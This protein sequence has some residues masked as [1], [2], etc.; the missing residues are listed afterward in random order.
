MKIQTGKGCP[1][2]GGEVAIALVREGWTLRVGNTEEADKD[3]LQ[4]ARHMD[5]EIE[6][7]L[8]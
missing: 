8:F 3:P 1:G 4:G 7:Y 6:L 5:G 2:R